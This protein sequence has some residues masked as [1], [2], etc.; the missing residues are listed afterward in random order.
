M[1]AFD[2]LAD[3]IA[4]DGNAPGSRRLDVRFLGSEHMAPDCARKS[5][6]V[7]FGSKAVEQSASDLRQLLRPK[8]PSLSSVIVRNSKHRSALRRAYAINLSHTPEH[9]E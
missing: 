6:Y 8:Q 9:Q 1:S 3:M 2:G 4:A 7:G 5:S